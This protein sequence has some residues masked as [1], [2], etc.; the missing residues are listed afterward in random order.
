MQHFTKTLNRKPG[1][2]FRIPTEEELDA[3]EAFQLFN[4]KQKPRDFFSVFLAGFTGFALTSVLAALAQTPGELIAAR[5]L[6]GAS[7]ACVLPPALSLIAV[8]FPPAERPGALAVWASVA[9]VGL[10]AGPVLGGILA[11]SFDLRAPFIAHAIICLLAIIPSFILIRETAPHLV[12]GGRRPTGWAST[13]RPHDPTTPSRVRSR[14]DPPCAGRP[15]R[16]RPAGP[17]SPASGRD[18]TSTALRT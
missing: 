5:V 17:R 18:A 2:D 14:A 1:T 4:G 11:V 15:R 16:R 7:A 9:G 12:A 10:S 3:L 6:M 8:M 13:A